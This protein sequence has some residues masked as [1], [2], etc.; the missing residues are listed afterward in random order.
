VR[1]ILLFLS[2]IAAAVAALGAVTMP[3]YASPAATTTAAAP[4]AS[5]VNSDFSFCN[6]NIACFAAELHYAGHKSFTLSSIQLENSLCDNRSAFADVY[7]QNGF[8]HE[9]ENSSCNTTKDFSSAN[10]ND[11][12][13]VHYVYIRLY[14]CNL[15]IITGCSSVKNSQKHYNPYW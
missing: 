13:G 8:M 2:T 15:N 1:R 9:F 11:P 10:L 14:Q 3:A 7:D 6:S 4:A 5:P 12:D